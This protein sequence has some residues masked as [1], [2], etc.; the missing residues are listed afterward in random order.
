MELG[1]ALK[2]FYVSWSLQPPPSLHFSVLFPT[3][4][5]HVYDF[6]HEGRGGQQ[7]PFLPIEGSGLESCIH[8]FQAL[9]TE[10]EVGQGRV[11]HPGGLPG[12]KGPHQAP[13][14]SR[15]TC[16]LAAPVP[17]HLLAHRR[18]RHLGEFWLSPDAPTTPIRQKAR[19]KIRDAKCH[20]QPRSQERAKD[21]LRHPLLGKWATSPAYP[22]SDKVPR[23]AGLVCQA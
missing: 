3:R 17:H 15:R 18:G 7:R 2:R 22:E 1:S 14:S 23:P 10:K 5:S 13:P 8:L 20:L 6:G 4:T 11:L 12:Q 9:Q 16:P 19:F 21:T